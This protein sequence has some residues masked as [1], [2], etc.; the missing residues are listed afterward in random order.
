MLFI[1][2]TGLS[3][4]GKTTISNHVKFKLELDGLLV[5]IVDGDIYRK[6]ICKDLGF[7][8]ADRC[9]NI[10]RLGA[11]AYT[12]CQNNI[13]TIL[14]VINPFEEIRNELKEKYNVKTVYIDCDLS[15]LLSRDTKGLYKRALLENNH[16]DKI[17]NLTGINDIYEAPKH[18]DLIIKT[19]DENIEQSVEKLYKFI[20]IN[21]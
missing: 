21:I 12:L 16:P 3:G 15:T 5:E 6:T 2:L 9:E 20:L 10:R 1:Q 7:S 14:S 13:I 11:L 17:S 18:P 8:K 19:F 4:A